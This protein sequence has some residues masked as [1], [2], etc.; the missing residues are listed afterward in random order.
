M[1]TREQLTALSV[2]ELRRMAREELRALRM[3]DNRTAKTQTAPV[4]VTGSGKAAL[5]DMLLHGQTNPPATDPEQIEP[6]EAAPTPEPTE[7]IPT[8]SEATH[9]AANAIFDALATLA[10]TTITID[11]VKEL[12]TAE[13]KRLIPRQINVTTEYST[14]AITGRQHKDF[15]LCLKIVGAGVPLMLVGPAGSGKTHLCAAIGEALGL[16]FTP[17]SCDES[18]Q[19]FDMTGYNDAQGRY[20]PGVLHDPFVHGRLLLLDEIDRSGPAL[21]TL[22]AAL[23][24]GYMTFPNGTANRHD[25]FRC[26]AAA[27]T[28]GTGTDWLYTSANRIDAATRDRFAM[29]LFDYDEG[30]EKSFAGIDTPQ[31]K[32]YKAKTTATPAEWYD[33]V[34]GIRAAAEKTK[35]PVIVSPRVTLY[36]LR[37]LDAGIDLNDCLNLLVWNKTDKQTA[38]RIKGAL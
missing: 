2:D 7:D 19:R 11:T 14:K 37:L 33:R 28:I 27:N 3:I 35:A 22:N 1:Q 16:E 29:H 15:E 4:F 12:V 26:V 38:D 24:N 9:S 18:T 20:V 31:P 13:V 6:I 32:P 34:S 17:Y 25:Q 21:T 36:G 10:K 23:A 5:I 30:L 8:P